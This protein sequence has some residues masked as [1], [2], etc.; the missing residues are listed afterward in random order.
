MENRQTESMNKGPSMVVRACKTSYSGFRDQ[1][2][3][4][5]RL[6]KAKS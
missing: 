3:H 1:K 5:L 6:A 4:V 2:D